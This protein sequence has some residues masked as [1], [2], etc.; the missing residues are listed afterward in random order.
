[1]MTSSTTVT[2]IGDAIIDIFLNPQ[3]SGS[4][5]RRN[6]KTGELCFVHGQKIP[7]ETAEICLGGNASNVAIGMRRLGF[8]T[9]VCAEIGSDIFAQKIVDVFRTEHVALSQL[10]QTPNAITSFAVVLNIQAERTIFVEHVKRDHPFSLAAITSEWVY[11]TSLGHKWEHV[12][13]QA[14]IIVKEKGL[15]LAFNPGTLQLQEGLDIVT[16]LLPLTDI[17]FVNKEEAARLAQTNV[18]SPLSEDSVIKTLFHVLQEMGVKTVVLTDG[19][20]GSYASDESKQI[21]H[22]GIFPHTIVER[23]GAG[24]AYAVGFLAGI[25]QG[26]DVAEAMRWGT[27]NAGSVI[28]HTGAQKG[29]LTSDTIKRRLE[30]HKQILARTV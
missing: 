16:K 7:L 12:Y 24:D 20:D 13:N 26:H 25:L 9:A 19:K 4:H 27:A 6:E 17:L 29:L 14:A 28:E 30:E 8:D 21:Y 15:K 18:E 2:T 11:L 10:L 22:M 1:M 3:A 23:T 5:F